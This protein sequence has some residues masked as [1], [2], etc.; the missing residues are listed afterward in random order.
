MKYIFTLLTLWL[1]TAISFAQSAS[2][3]QSTTSDV[4][5]DVAV[6]KGSGF[7][8]SQMTAI[9][10][11][12][13]AVLARSAVSGN[14]KSSYVL[15]PTVTITNKDTAENSIS[16]IIVIRG[17]LTIIAM[18]RYNQTAYNELTIPLTV[19]QAV[20]TKSD[21]ILSLINSFNIRDKRIVRFLKVTQKRIDSY[22]KK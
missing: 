8:Q 2:S 7:T 4:T 21:D 20:T 5:F 3:E 6:Q 16:P 19:S 18:N 15:I 17:E 11:K 12:L 22:K 1:S 10:T 13:Q 9:V 14:G